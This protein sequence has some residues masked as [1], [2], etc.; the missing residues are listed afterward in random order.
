VSAESSVRRSGRPAQADA[1]LIAARILD[2]GTEAFLSD[3]YAASSIERIAAA[4]G[5][6]KRTLYARFGDKAALF[7]AAVERLISSWLE[8]F[9]SELAEPRSLEE[10]LVAGGDRIVSVALSPEALALHR[11]VVGESG[12]FPELVAMLHDAGAKAGVSRI[13]ALL[14]Q[15]AAR[16]EVGDIDP[17]FAA[18]QFMALVL[19]GPQRRALGFAPALDEAGRRTWV[20][21]SVALFLE[22]CRG[23]H[24]L[25]AEQPRA[26][27]EPTPV[28]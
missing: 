1:A 23:Q 14:R 13:A 20:R 19:A 4:A 24:A 2:A 21:R 28:T 12:R 26:H 6:G 11:L 9:E 17:I 5:V 16:G 27:G 3:G 18:E 10:A 22:G 25:G 15:A 8:P 7:R